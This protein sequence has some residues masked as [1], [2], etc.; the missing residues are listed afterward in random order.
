MYMGMKRQPQIKTH[1]AK[2][3]PFFHCPIMSNI[4]NQVVEMSTHYQPSNL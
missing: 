3:G 4:M 1:W 2:Q